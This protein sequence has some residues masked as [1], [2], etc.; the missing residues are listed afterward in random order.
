MGISINSVVGCGRAGAEG[1]LFFTE[2]TAGWVVFF[3]R[4]VCSIGASTGEDVMTGS[5]NV[6]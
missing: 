2:G 6:R 3:D 4:G 1:I 5:F